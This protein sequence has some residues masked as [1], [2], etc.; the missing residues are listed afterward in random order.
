VSSN[1]SLLLFDAPVV[2]VD[3][4]TVLDE[5]ERTTAAH[6]EPRAPRRTPAGQHFPTPA[7]TSC[8]GG[9]LETTLFGVSTQRPL[10][11]AA[12]RCP[13]LQIAGEQPLLLCAGK[14]TGLAVAP[15]SSRFAVASD[16][17]GLDVA[18][19]AALF[20]GPGKV[21]RLGVATQT[22]RAAFT[23][24]GSASREDELA[25]LATEQVLQLGC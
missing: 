2:G 5:M 6:S 25:T 24:I 20:D 8:L 4:L 15:D 14:R 11:S 18:R 23:Q 10:F 21:P 9:S 16:P 7:Q 13:F 12:S 3:E 17:A 1:A 19:N 22:A